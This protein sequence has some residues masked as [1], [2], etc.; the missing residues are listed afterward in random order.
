MDG[1]K[2]I[3]VSLFFESPEVRGCKLLT[4]CQ[5]IHCPGVNRFDGLISWYGLTIRTKV[6]IVHQKYNMTDGANSRADTK[7]FKHRGRI[8]LKC[9]NS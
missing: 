1:V 5:K 2:K 3:T 4:L 9:I 6:G 8:N 7:Q